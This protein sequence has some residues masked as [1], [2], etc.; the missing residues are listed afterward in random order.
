MAP[1]RT[2]RRPRLGAVIQ[3]WRS[4][5]LGQGFREMLGNRAETGQGFRR[6]GN[7]PAPV[8]RWISRDRHPAL[9]LEVT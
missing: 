1:D 3:H 2:Q 7:K 5:N 6:Q 9:R 8:I 4:H